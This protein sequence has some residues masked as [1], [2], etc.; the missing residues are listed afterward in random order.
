VHRGPHIA[1]VDVD[2]LTIRLGP[3][4]PFEEAV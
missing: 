2:L 4:G 3:M 1:L